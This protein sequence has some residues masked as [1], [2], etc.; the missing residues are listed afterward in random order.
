[1]LIAN[2]GAVVLKLVVYTPSTAMQTL[3]HRRMLKVYHLPSR[4]PKEA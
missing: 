1:L 4:I 3:H 2:S